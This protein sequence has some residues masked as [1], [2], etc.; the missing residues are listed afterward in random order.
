LVLKEASLTCYDVQ[1]NLHRLFEKKEIYF[2]KA[3]RIE[4]RL[5]VAPD[6]LISYLK[7]KAKWLKNPRVELSNG[8]VSVHGRAYW[9]P[10]DVRVK[11]DLLPDKSAVSVACDSLKILKIPFPGGLLGSFQEKV[12]SLESSRKKP[13]S[14]VLNSL[15]IENGQ[16]VVK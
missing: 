2:V 13:F 6:T 15:E 8:T 14:V 11:V 16:L 4:L 9:I 7:K 10:L 5:R 1:V 3:G 12:F